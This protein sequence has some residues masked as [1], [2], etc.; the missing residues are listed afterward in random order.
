MRVAIIGSGLAAISAAKSLVDRGVKPIILDYGKIL[1]ED[2]RSVVL[3]LS[4]L[5]PDQWTPRKRE[6]IVSNPTVNNKNSFPQKLAFGSDYFYGDSIHN[7]PVETDGLLPPFSYAKGGFSVGWGASVLPPDDCDLQ[8]WP[9]E[10]GHLEHYFKKVL[11]S[12]PYSACDDGLSEHFPLYSDTAEP[13]QLT[14]GNAQLLKDLEKLTKLNRGMISFG[15]SRLLVRST[16]NNELTGCKYCGY[17]MSGCVYGCIYKSNQDLDRLVSAGLVDYMQGI[18]VHS[19]QEIDDKVQVSFFNKEGNAESLTFDRVFLGAGAVGST[20]IVLQSKRLYQHE[21][22]LL[23]TVNFIA[24]ILRM[25]SVP[26]DWPNANTLPSL[27]L[28]FKV[29]GLS[30]HWVH[31]QLS[32]PN[33]MAFEKLGIHPSRHGLRQAIKKRMAKHLVIAH[34]NMHSDHANG[35]LLS[36]KKGNLDGVD[37]FLSRREEINEPYRAIKQAKRKLFSMVRSFGWYTLT[38]FVLD[39]IRS[40]GYHVGGTLPMK[41]NTE[42]GT[43][44]NLLG[45]PKGWKRIHIVDSSVFPSL[46]GTTIGLLAMANAARIATEVELG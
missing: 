19:L 42:K 20:R 1:D 28:E 26:I 22:R 2:R 34:C 25:E 12:L 13:L 43:D 37:K 8:A 4:R 27:F 14:R 17:C 32:T 39:G 9:I 7:A 10:R 21:V 35:Y 18:L 15:Q 33:E 3:E 6:F 30:N 29:E 41:L 38:P 36:L 45:S 44:T 46:P 11:S 16:E 5:K 31:T 24:P 40:G 23:S